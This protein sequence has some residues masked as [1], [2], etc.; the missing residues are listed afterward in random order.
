MGRPAALGPRAAHGSGWWSC[1]RV[2]L[3]W[4][5]IPR[6]A[7]ARTPLHEGP[8]WGPG[9]TCTRTWA[10]TWRSAR[11]AASAA[12][13]CPAAASTGP[14]SAPP[15]STSLSSRTRSAG[16]ARWGGLTPPRGSLRMLRCLRQRC[17]R[18]PRPRSA[19]ACD[20]GKGCMP[21]VGGRFAPV[22]AHGRAGER[23]GGCAAGRDA[24]QPGHAVD[25]VRRLRAHGA[26]LPAPAAQLQRV[27]VGQARRPRRALARRLR[28][29]GAA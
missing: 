10:W 9:S 23:T 20:A 1:A 19:G 25:A 7:R 5:S 21:D 28:C 14:S 3:I 12:C 18:W 8:V 13:G 11:T 17:R 29:A 27:L 26:D 15:C 24:A 2:W 22:H 4:R 16:G 6:R